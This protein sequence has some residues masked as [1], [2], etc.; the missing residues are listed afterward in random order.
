MPGR[1]RAIVFKNR[2]A[3]LVPAALVLVV[4]GRPTVA[5]AS[6][7]L[8]IALAGECLRIW[9]V[10][11]SGETTRGDA[12]TAP[13]LVTAGPYAAI[14]NPLYAGNGFIALG[15]WIAFAGGVSLLDASVMLALVLGLVAAVY[16]TIIPLEETYLARE[17]G[18]EYECYRAEVPRVI[19]SAALLARDK[20][21]GTWRGRVI[22]RAEAITLVFFLLMSIV[23]LLKL[24]PLAPF[25]L[26]F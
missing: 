11:F 5:S 24:G 18:A 7:G 9:A 16:A 20:R 17:F 3:L 21:R 23:V 8:L 15:F 22:A 25:G 4:F 26:Y 19:P 14:R 2:G 12:V 13:A 10:G 6:I 1:W